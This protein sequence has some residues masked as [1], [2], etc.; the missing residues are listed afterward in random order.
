MGRQRK[1][2]PSILSADFARLAEEVQAAEKAGA[3]WIHFDVMDGRFVPNITVGPLVLEAVRKVTKLPLD[4]HLMIVE[5][6]KYVGDFVKAGANWVTVHAE[7]S[8]HLD[9]LLHQIKEAGAKC[10]VALN[11]AT[12]LSAVDHV[13]GTVDLILLMTVNP[14]FGGQKFIESCIPKIRELRRKIDASGREIVLEIDGGVK[15]DNIGRVAGSDVD[16][17]VAGSAVF[18][19][20]DYGSAI[21]SLRNG[22]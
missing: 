13:L 14:G 19:Q 12:P 10:G 7:A 16:V 20:K 3:D 2:A 1:I 11:P 9:R 15:A 6:E 17:V 18:G 4:A 8:V 5:P 21:R 22:A